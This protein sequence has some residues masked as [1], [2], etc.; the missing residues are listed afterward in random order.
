MNFEEHAAKAIF[1]DFGIPVPEGRLARSAHEAAG[2]AAELARPVMIKA[3]VPTGGRGKAG[4]ILEAADPGAARVQAERLIG[5]I[6]AGH[7]V[8]S[9]LVERRASLVRELYAAVLGDPAT[10]GPLLLFSGDGGV[11]IEVL[12]AAKPQTLRRMPIDIREGLTQAMAARA[13]AGLGASEAALADLL[14]RLYRVWRENDAELVEINPLAITSDGA[15]LALDGKFVLD[16]AAAKRHL[17]LVPR[18][19]PAP[20]TELERRARDLGLTYVELDG[21]VGVL[22]NG[23]GLTMATMDAIRH[24][25]GRAANFLEIGGE[26]YRLARPALGI[27]VDNPRV[28]S[29]LVNFCGAFARTD[30]MTGG[31]I[32]AWLEARP[33]LPVAFSVAGTGEEQAAALIRDKL[34]MEPCSSMDEAVQTAVAA[35]R[36]ESRR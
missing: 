19:A 36:R 12:A 13:V 17:E 7:R 8:S 23:A 25:G 9:V 33:S 31:L 4:G 28:K 1:R 3:Q 22:A 11:E 29:L 21:D 32:A 2:I 6:I 15:A 24:H 10:R 27:V 5:R 34:A 35:A 16:D 18:A 14:C 30:V 20:L 26:A